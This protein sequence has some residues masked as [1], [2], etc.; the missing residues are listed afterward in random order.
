M[1]WHAARKLRRAVEAGRDV[2]AIEL[3]AGAR[4]MALRAPLEPSPV[5]GAVVTRVNAASGGPGHDRWLAPEL[6]A[7]GELVR[8]GELLDLVGRFVALRDE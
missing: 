4:A 5:I 2:L 1:G 7:V 3:V 8:N 6:A